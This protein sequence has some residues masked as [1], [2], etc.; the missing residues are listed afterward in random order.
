MY[1]QYKTKKINTWSFL[2]LLTLSIYFALGQKAFANTAISP[3]QSQ[4]VIDVNP[5]LSTFLDPDNL[6]LEQLLS[7]PDIDWEENTEAKFNFAFSEATLWARFTI[8]DIENIAGKRFLNIDYTHLDL[9]DVYYIQNGRLLKHY[10]VGDTIPFSKR[11]L[12]FRTPLFP[13]PQSVSGNVDVYLKVVTNGPQVIPLELTSRHMVDHKDKLLFAWIGAYAGIMAVMFLYNFFLYTVLREA[14][15]IYYLLYIA[16][17]AAL[18]ISLEGFNFRYLWPN[19]PAIN[20]PHIILLSS[21][22]PI[23]AVAFIAKFLKLKEQGNIFEI[24][25]ARFLFVS[26]SLIFVFSLALPYALSLK[27]TYIL[28]YISILFGFYL[29]VRYAFIKSEAPK[30]FALAWGIYLVCI[31][32]YLMD[33]QGHITGSFITEHAMQIG[34]VIE[35]TLLSIAL[36]QRISS[37]K[38][39]RYAAL[40]EKAA[41][42]AATEAKSL[43]LANMSHEIRTPMNGVTGVIE[44][45]KDSKL[46]QLQN[47]YINIIHS[48]SMSL[49]N[50]IDDILD[51]SKIESGKMEVEAIPMQLHAQL[52]DCVAILAP[53]SEEKGLSVYIDH[54]P[55]IP[56]TLFSDPTRI[57]QILLNFL[58]NSVKFTEQGSITIRSQL[59]DDKKVKVSVIDTGIGISKEAQAKLFSS[60]SQAE[61][62][63]TRQFG[64]TGLGLAISKMLSSLLGGEVGIESEEGVGSE[65]WFSFNTQLSIT[66]ANTEAKNAHTDQAWP[67]CNKTLVYNLADSSLWSNIQRVLESQFRSI[68]KL[69]GNPALIQHLEST[70]NSNDRDHYVY[71]CDFDQLKTLL[72]DSNLQANKDRFHVLFQHNEDTRAEAQQSFNHLIEYPLSLSDIRS[73]GTKL[74]AHSVDLRRIQSLNLTGLNCLVAEDNQ[75]NQLVI[76]GL[77]TKF[78]ANVNLVND[79]EQAQ[80]YIARHHSE[81][82]VI[83]MDIEMPNRNGYEATQWIREFE[84]REGLTPTPIFGLSAHALESYI[85]KGEALG[86]NGFITKPITLPQLIKTLSPYDRPDLSQSA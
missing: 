77:L 71:L 1:S 65:F 68:L 18:Q 26:F 51:Y 75:V 69:E 42:E 24:T 4:E 81:I 8:L 82:D 7:F 56:D 45:L 47:R 23:C 83:F 60:Y 39:M 84:Q 38:R 66:E 10:Q 70:E 61:T 27:S 54:D 67:K 30:S 52:D 36:A 12:D 21:L 80:N 14:S 76:K 73:V 62:S 32:A 72:H 64:G 28:A 20:N 48:S 29:G 53:R 22:M 3:T 86:M 79:G 46:D 17:T 34:S 49:L 59:L 50:I 40:K 5:Y 16:A 15:Y 2:F 31:M 25:V 43:F 85:S 44:L 11:P 41:A 33:V 78:D 37:E 58:S 19:T 35:I 74:T 6:S 57:R 55:N 63:T 13:L 9:V